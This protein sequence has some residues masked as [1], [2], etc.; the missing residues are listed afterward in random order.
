M[1]FLK[2]NTVK[3]GLK[4]IVTTVLIYLVFRY[5]GVEKVYNELYNLNANYIFLAFL[6]TFPLIFFKAIRWKGIVSIFN[7]SIRTGTSVIYTLISIAFAIVTPSRL[8]EFIKVKYLTDKTRIRYLKSF[9]TVVID[10][11]FDIIAMV[12]LGLLGFSFLDAT[13]KWAN[14]F[15]AVFFLYLLILVFVFLF[16]DKFLTFVPY[17]LPKK[18]REGFKKIAL[19]RIIY[20]KSILISLVIWLILSIQAFL[21]LNSLEVKTSLLITITAIPLMALSAIVPISIGGIG[22]R[23]LIAISFFSLLGVSAEKSAIF[24]LLYTFISSGI[25]AIAGAFLHFFYKKAKV[26]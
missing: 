15:V 11:G 18:Y 12:F 24:S 16:F 20:L 25:P 4:F 10:K 1:K 22:V 17:F 5:V 9:S 19:T 3:L 7:T 23:E 14:L 8:G 2:S 21:I 13:A 6:F 26:F